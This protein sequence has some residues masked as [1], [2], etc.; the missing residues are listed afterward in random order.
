[1]YASP[2]DGSEMAGSTA[3]RLREEFTR[4]L[5]LFLRSRAA[6][7]ILNADITRAHYKSCLRE[8]YFYTRED[9]Q[10]QAYATAWFKGEGRTIV[11]T[12][13]KHAISEVGHDQLALD[14]LT[15]LGEDTAGISMEYPLPTT[16][17][18]TS[19][20]YWATQFL[21]PVSYLGYLYFLEA[22][23][24]TAGGQLLD[25]LTKA[26]IP[27]EAMTFLLEHSTIDFAHM[28]LMDLY[29]ERLIRSE[30]DVADVAYA[31]R[32]TGKLYELML[33]GAFAAAES[34]PDR[35]ISLG[36]REHADDRALAVG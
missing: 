31:I 4:T 29:V 20:P 7:R 14:D 36:E 25:A 15:A 22:L 28:K 1:M 18:L 32:T 10:L 3:H 30:R 9:P 34:E 24:T 26:E 23:P 8:T 33:D 5:E 21:N 35:T 13:L 17:A 16:V 12:F 2:L 27:R 19:F 11:K 6:Q